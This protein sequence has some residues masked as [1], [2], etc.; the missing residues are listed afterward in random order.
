MT[1]SEPYLAFAQ[2]V[3]APL[4]PLRIKRMFGGAG[5]YSGEVFFAILADDTLYLKADARSRDAYE[6]RGLRPF[7]YTRKDGRAAHLS[8]YPLPA[9][10]LEDP[11][12]LVAWA[13]E[14]V[15]AAQRDLR[16]S[17]RQAE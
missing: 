9:D 15:A 14:A 7:T 12:A 17:R 6:A 13:R 16:R 1:V 10:I 3:L 8:Y 5:V 11:E 2:D 4:A